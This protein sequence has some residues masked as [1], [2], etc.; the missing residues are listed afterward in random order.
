MLVDRA[1]GLCYHRHGSRCPGLGLIEQ[2]TALTTPRAIL[3]T[4]F[5]PS[6]DALAALLIRRLKQADPSLQVHALGGPKMQAA[7]AE[8]I[9][10]TTEQAK[11]LLG[12]ATEAGT[13]LK[14]LRRLKRWLA[15]HRI[16]ALVPTD[17]PAANWS[18][19]GLIRKHQ[20]HAAIIHLVC[21]QVWAWAT[22]R[23]HRLRR[24]T[25]HV[26]CLLPHEVDYLRE[27]DVSG[28]FVGH[29]LFPPAAL[30][31]SVELP[32]SSGP[33]L[34]LLPGS[35]SKEIAMNWPP[36]L[37]VFKQLAAA[38]PGLTGVVAARTAADI[39][40]VQAA[41]GPIP[42]AVTIRPAVTDEVIAWSD[43]ALV[44]SGTATLQ[45]AARRKPMVTLFTMNRL[46]VHTLA[47]ALVKART[48]AL[49]N[50][51]AESMGMDRVVPEFVPHVGPAEPIAA[52]LSPLLTDSAARAA[53][54]AAF[55]R[56]AERF[57]SVRFEEAAAAVLLERLG[58]PA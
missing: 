37:E 21:P 2:A 18:I 13:H 23:I 49:P 55:E 57:E 3:F 48:F 51:V 31:A 1:R 22:W 5:E 56:I 32:A 12:A 38:H 28:T 47:R 45:V 20:P 46:V 16:D 15:E 33:K 36:M 53:Q 34:A 11:M 6:G 10:T 8:L 26:L 25:D 19:C 17:S 52:A 58:R 39:A 41:A 42:D 44:V 40:R 9:E 29:P 4:A 30:D 14:R 7:G 50:L 24:L 27:H 54:V 43:A 35:R